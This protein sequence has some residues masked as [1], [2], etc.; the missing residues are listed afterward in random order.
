MNRP[1]R[2]ADGSADFGKPA[3]DAAPKKN[4][5]SGVE[6]LFNA[7]GCPLHLHAGAGAGF[8]K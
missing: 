3:D 4:F 1:G 2:E 8:L 7:W 5:R 6:H